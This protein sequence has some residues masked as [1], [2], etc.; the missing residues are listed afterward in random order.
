MAITITTLNNDSAVAKTFTEIGKDRVSAEWVNTT[1]A[2]ATK[3]GKLTIKQTILSKT[4]QNVPLR[5]TLVSYQVVGVDDGVNSPET[6]TVN[7]TITAPEQLSVLGG[8]DRHD[9]V[10]Y[11]RNLLTSAN[12][13]A[14][15]Q[16]QV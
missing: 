6:V 1:D 8:S 10:A 15:T 12:V 9:A 2:T 7:F 14:L 11:L 5:R 4:K 13:T 16:G 3:N